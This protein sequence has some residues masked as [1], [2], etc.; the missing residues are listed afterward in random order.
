MMTFI[1]VVR[2]A[3]PAGGEIQINGRRGEQPFILIGKL[4]HSGETYRST[5]QSDCRRTGAGPVVL[6]ERDRGD[7][8]A[9]HG[10]AGVEQAPLRQCVGD[11]LGPDQGV[12]GAEIG[13][14]CVRA[15]ATVTGITL[16]S[17]IVIIVQYAR[18]RIS[19]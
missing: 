3:S 4:R 2:L 10:L 12:P 14:A 9:Q 17:S 15:C 1:C 7:R 18:D 5:G 19:H 13:T 16:I 8:S 11:R 6:I